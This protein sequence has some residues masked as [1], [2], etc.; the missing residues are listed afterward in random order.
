MDKA[1]VFRFPLTFTF[2]RTKKT[3]TATGKII[4]LGI[5]AFLLYSFIVSDL[6]KKKNAQTLSQDL[7]QISRPKMSFSK[8]N[9][10]MVF[11]VAND[12]NIFFTDETIYSFVFYIYHS[13]IKEQIVNQ[14]SS[15]LKLCTQDD[16]MED[17]SE[18]SR[19]NLN[20][21]Y[22]LPTEALKLGGFWDEE[23]I[24]YFWIELRTCQNSSSSD[25]I[26][27]SREEI[28]EYLKNNYV[29]IYISDHNIDSSNYLK[30]LTRNLK[31]FYQLLDPKLYKSVEL[32]MKNS[33]IT[34]DDGFFFE[35]L[36]VIESFIQG[37]IETDVSLVQ[38]EENVIYCLSIYSSNFQT[39][40]QRNYQK[41]Q[42]LLAQLGGICNLLFLF[43]LT[44][45]KFEN[46]YNLVSLLSNE[47][48]IFPTLQKKSNLTKKYLTSNKSHELIIPNKISEN[49][50]LKQFSNNNNTNFQIEYVSN[51]PPSFSPKKTQSILKL[52]K[53]SLDQNKNESNQEVKPKILVD[54]EISADFH[55]SQASQTSN[56]NKHPKEAISPG[57]EVNFPTMKSMSPYCK[58][59]W[60]IKLKSMKNLWSSIKSMNS[61][62]NLMMGNLENYQILKKKENFFSLGFVGFLIIQLK[63][64]LFCFFKITNREKLFKTAEDEIADELDI[65]KILKKLQ[66]IEKLKRILLNEDQLYLFN[67]LSKP[68]IIP[69][70][71][72]QQEKEQEKNIYDQRFKFSLKE[73]LNLEKKKLFEIYK[74]VKA[75]ENDSQVDKKLIKLLDEDVMCFLKNEKL[76]E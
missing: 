36:K 41:I 76:I 27:K 54:A 42:S 33:L 35:S 47:L 45:C 1:D 60:T 55:E 62:E 59:S 3:S 74:S 23:T 44:L 51:L 12:D 34:T 32:Y 16:F 14:T 26:C 2:K 15:V 19:L 66:E 24:D 39:N 49:E 11:G 61:P 48:F 69:E 75:K 40:V 6:T 68:M 64:K 50:R 73:N 38:S 18:F 53:V 31:I 30:P 37:E 5:L 52:C 21:T 25:I 71:S 72:L 70:N 17:P 65:I 58:K 56:E 9:F 57:S 8:Q 29:D 63:K 28:D 43:G 46:H 20:G 7:I 13:N 10:T 22:C 4:T 67:L